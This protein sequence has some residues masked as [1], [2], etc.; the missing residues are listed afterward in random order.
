MIEWKTYPILPEFE[1][2]LEIGREEADID[3]RLREVHGGLSLFYGASFEKM[4]VPKG[5]LPKAKI[6]GLELIAVERVDQAV[7]ALRNL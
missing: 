5:N 6:G 4:I 7:Q 1:H 2:G 3:T